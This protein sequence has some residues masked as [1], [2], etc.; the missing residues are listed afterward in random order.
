MLYIKIVYIHKPVQSQ[1]C[2]KINK[3]FRNKYLSKHIL[4]ILMDKWIRGL[5]NLNP[6]KILVEIF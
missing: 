2:E 3:P 4:E 6:E 1:F 5:E